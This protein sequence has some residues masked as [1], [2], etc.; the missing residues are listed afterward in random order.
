MIS[1]SY[2]G[3]VFKYPSFPHSFLDIATPVFYKAISVKKKKGGDF[4][5]KIIAVLFCISLCLTL[6]GTATF[7]F[8]QECAVSISRDTMPKSHWTAL[9]ALIRIQTGGFDISQRTKVTF[10]SDAE[11]GIFQSVIPLV[12]LVNQNV[13]IINQFAIIM[14]AILTGNFG[15]ETETITVSVEGC[16][17]NAQFELNILSLSIP[18]SE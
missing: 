8:G 2:K 3:C 16:E 12:K 13:G 10:T 14:P 4:M 1:N 15:A 5:K 11:G 7:A 17:N 6:Q 18:L 9:P